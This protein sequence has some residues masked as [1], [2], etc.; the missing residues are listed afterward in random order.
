GLQL[1]LQTLAR[2]RDFQLVYRSAFVNGRQSRGAHGELTTDEALEQ[3]LDGTGLTYR[4][5]D[6]SGVMIVPIATGGARAAGVSR[7][8]DVESAP[9]P[10]SYESPGKGAGEHGKAGRSFWDRF[11]VAQV[12]QGRGAS[13]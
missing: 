8:A 7:V 4:Y 12:D 5:L 11:R 2:D 1:A 6:D 10:G 9:P 13:S 3:V